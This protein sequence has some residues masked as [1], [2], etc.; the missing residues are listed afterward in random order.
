[1]AYEMK[2]DSGSLFKNERKEK[3][4]HADYQGE[5]VI[6]GKTYYMNA[7]INQSKNGKRY[8]G[9]KFKAKDAQQAPDFAEAD[10]DLPF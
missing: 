7:W 4:T 1:M 8:L 3:E 2:P 6:D 10:S 9:L 5:C